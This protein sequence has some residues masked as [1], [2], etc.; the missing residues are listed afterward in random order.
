M[1]KRAQVSTGAQLIHQPG[2]GILD[3]TL[4]GGVRTTGLQDYKILKHNRSSFDPPSYL[5]KP[6]NPVGLTWTA[7]GAQHRVTLSA[8][9]PSVCCIFRCISDVKVL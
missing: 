8:L 7:E 3:Q 4:V 6:V 5:W 9:Q 1:L 2:D